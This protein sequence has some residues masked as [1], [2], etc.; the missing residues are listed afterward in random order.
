MTEQT[1]HDHQAQ[2]PLKQAPASWKQPENRAE[3]GLIDVLTQLARRK[4]LIGKTTALALLSGVILG[5]LLPVRYTATTKLMP[6]QQ[7]QSTASMMMNQLT[8]IGAGS[9]AAVASGGFGMK[10]PNDIY[11]GLLTSRPV[12]DAIIQQFSLLH[13]YRAKDM[14]AA[15]NNL[16]RYTTVASE[17]NGFIAVSVTD[18]DRQRAA[19]MANAYTKELRT[20]TKTLAVT[21]A[22]Q[23]R[24]FYEDQLK[25]AKEALLAAEESFQ[26][27]QQVK[28]VVQ[29]DDQAKAMIESLALLRAQ[30]AAKEVEVQ[31]LRSYSTEHNPAVEL[32]QGEL[33]SLRGETIRLEQRNHSSGFADL[34]LGDVPGAG[35]EYLR[36]EHELKYRQAMFDLLIKQTD[37]ARLDE[38]KDA[39][40][41][42]VVELAI[43][44]DH[45]TDP[46]RTSIVLM[47]TVCGFLGSCLYLYVCNVIEENLEVSQSLTNLKLALTRK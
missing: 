38:A 21:E 28:G 42:Q 10:N 45:K 25:Q 17:K 20:I 9:L 22:G 19:A 46:N 3:V 32:A 40:I 11:I 2:V 5:L 12:A 27:V 29:L 18:K 30:V 23:R 24:L 8:N 33:A 43:P 15:R 35:M 13:A 4:W 26:Q 47:F 1:M 37:A 34:G 41:I 36:A 31:A 44:P 39:A 6:P 7:T 16:A 14:T